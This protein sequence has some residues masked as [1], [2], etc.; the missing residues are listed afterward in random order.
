MKTVWVKAHG[1]SNPSAC[2]KA[3]NFGAFLDKIQKELF[4]NNL[5]SVFWEAFGAISSCFCAVV[6]ILIS[7]FTFWYSNRRKIKVHIESNMHLDKISEDKP[8]INQ[9]GLSDNIVFYSIYDIEI[10][11]IGNMPISI[12]DFGIIYRPDKVYFPYKHFSCGNNIQLP[13]KLDAKDLL[14]FSISQ[15]EILQVTR[16]SNCSEVVFYCRTSTQYIKKTINLDL[17][18]NLNVKEIYVSK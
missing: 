14:V 16:E 3:P 13:I 12:L 17:P 9:E 2:A 10:Q 7:V 5:L 1:G 15:K 18:D 4:M 6:A 8:L 11:N